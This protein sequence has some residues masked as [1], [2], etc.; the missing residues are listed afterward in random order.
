MLGAGAGAV[1]GESTGVTE[2]VVRA[3]F[4]QAYRTSF[5]RLLPGVAARIVNL[6]TAA[7]GRR[8]HFDLR[9]LAPEAGATVQGAARGTRP[10]WFAGAWHEAAIY[11]RLELPV[12][13]S[14]PGPAILEQP[15]ATTVVDP[16]LTARVDELG[17]VI[18]EATA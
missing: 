16:G 12:G 13:A 7:I 11:A 14:I 10:V 8:P 4:E 1:A 18:V 3:A 15:D 5:S 6:R 17:N 9:A 2:A